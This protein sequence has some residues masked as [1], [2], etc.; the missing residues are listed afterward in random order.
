M[1]SKHSDIIYAL[2]TPYQV[3]A[4]AIMRLTGAGCFA[5]FRK[6]LANFTQNPENNKIYLS[7]LYHPG[8]KKLIDQITF[9]KYDE[10]SFTGEE[11][12][13]IFLHGSLAVIDSLSELLTKLGFRLANPGEFSLRAYQNGKITLSQAEGIVNI[14]NSLTTKEANLAICSLS[15]SIDKKITQIYTIIQRIKAGLDAGLDFADE[16]I[17]LISRAEIKSKLKVAVNKLGQLL[18]NH[19][20]LK[21]SGKRPKV[22]IVGFPNAGKSSL[23]NDLLG[24]SRAIVSDIRGTTRDFIQET[25]IFDN[26]SFDLYDTAG[27][28]ISEDI[29]EKEGIKRSVSLL[30]SAETVI[31]LSDIDKLE[32]SKQTFIKDLDSKQVLVVISKSDKLTAKELKQGELKYSIYDPSSKAELLK[33]ITKSLQ[34]QEYSGEL[35]TS[36]QVEIALNCQKLIN[37][38][39]IKIDLLDDALISLELG[40]ILSEFVKFKGNNVIDDTAN[41]IFKNFCIGK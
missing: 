30:K 28:H 41:E 13:E 39:S 29:I 26:I 2:A 34:T 16:D 32:E 25:I 20:T 31:L 8:S 3:S 23:F 15:G 5:K 12:V 36:R 27:I 17:E 33:A 11:L 9:I 22:V 37:D 19:Q 35:I 1:P 4:L 18:G 21:Q 6:L 14:I 38:L 7:N 40:N 24:Y 10:K